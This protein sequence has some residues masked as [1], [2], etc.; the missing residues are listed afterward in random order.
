MK[1]LLFTGSLLYIFIKEV[2]KF[3]RARDRFLRGSAKV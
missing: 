3:I 1:P 2:D